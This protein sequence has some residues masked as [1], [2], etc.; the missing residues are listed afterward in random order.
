MRLQL[1]ISKEELM[2][3]LKLIRVWKHVK[4]DDQMFTVM[5]V[6]RACKLPRATIQ[7]K[8]ETLVEMGLILDGGYDLV[9]RG[10]SKVYK[11]L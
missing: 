7:K 6:V 5:S 4:K 11:T 10:K 9:G 1:Q 2:Q 3:H 8:L